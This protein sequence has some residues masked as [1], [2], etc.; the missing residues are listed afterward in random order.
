LLPFKAI[1]ECKSDVSKK[2]R[3]VPSV[4]DYMELRDSAQSL[5]VVPVE[6]DLAEWGIQRV[7]EWLQDLLV[8]QCF[9]HLKIVTLGKHWGKL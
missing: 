1:D 9:V 2:G 7:N 3:V 4:A 5:A 6:L 8:R